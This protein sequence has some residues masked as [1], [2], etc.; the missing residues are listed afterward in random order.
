[1]TA[2]VAFLGM[3]AGLGICITAAGLTGASLTPVKRPRLAV[4]RL[5]L[6]AALAIG[7]GVVTAVLTGWP[8]AVVAAAAAGAVLPSVR[9]NSAQRRH[10]LERSDAVA[11]W[12]ELLRDTM[13]GAAGLHEAIMTSARVAPPAIHP[14]IQTLSVRAEHQ[15]LSRALRRFAAEVHDPVGDSVV[16]ALIL[17]IEQ[18]AGSLASVLGQIATN[19][20]EQAAMRQRVEA[21]RA[22]TYTSV[23]FIVIVTFSFAVGLVLLA[24]DY[25]Q[26]F[27][28]LEGQLALA[29]VLGLFAAAGW[30]L[31]RLGRAE[32]PT[33]LWTEPEAVR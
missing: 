6:R 13:A 18:Q 21:S 7:L 25:L 8:V 33:R 12:A 30:S 24:P 3:L 27:N 22:R 10:A 28:T 32:S 5:T 2:I 1:V 19:A 11:T 31:R 26:P 4:D 15:P 9:R 17:S 23:R 29:V 16:A 14:E 20:R